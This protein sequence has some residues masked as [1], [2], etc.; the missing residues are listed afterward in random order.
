MLLRDRF[1]LFDKPLPLLLHLP[2]LFV[3]LLLDELFFA[4]LVPMLKTPR[5]EFPLPAVGES[6]SSSTRRTTPASSPFAASAA[7]AFCFADAPSDSL[8]AS[9]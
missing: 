2:L 3:L 1:A 9:V 8:R 4:E 5:R 7:A 6:T